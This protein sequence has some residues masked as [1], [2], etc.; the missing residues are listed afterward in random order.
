MSFLF[1]QIMAKQLNFFGNI[2]QADPYFKTPKTVLVISRN[3]ITKNSTSVESIWQAIRAHYG[4]QSTGSHFI[5]LINI[6]FDPDERPEDLFQR[7]MAFVEDSLLHPSCGLRHHD[8]AITEEEEL[9]P[10]LGNLVVLLWHLIN[11]DLPNLVKQKYGTKMRSPTLASIKS[12]I[13]Q[14]MD[15]LLDSIQS[16]NDAKVMR[17][18]SS[19][20][21]QQSQPKPQFKPSCPLCVACRRP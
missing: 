11:K 7:L 20:F 18:V 3:T 4:F 5:D 6:K 16:N 8:E 17:T 13:S 12:E 21:H 10:S 9:S 2:S 14:A 19:K 1:F 15:S